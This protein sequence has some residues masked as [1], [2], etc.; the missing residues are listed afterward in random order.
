M[1]LSFIK[2]V[3][4]SEIRLEVPVHD[5]IPYACHYDSN[6]IL[7]KNGELLQTIKL[8]GFSYETIG[9]EKV[10]L[11]DTVRESIL[12]NI[13]NDKLAVW[14][15]TVRTKRSLDPGAGIKYTN[16]FVQET[17][18]AW[19]HKN[20]WDDK[21]VNELYITVIHE[22]HDTKIHNLSDAMLSFSY[23]AQRYIHEEFLSKSH[24]E[25]NQTVNNMLIIL[26]QY[27]AK[28]LEIQEDKEGAYSEL[29]QFFD[30]IIHMKEE[31]I[32]VPLVEL[33]KYLATHKIAFG[34]NSFEVRNG[35]KKYFG[36]I[37]SIKEYSEL[38]ANDIDILLQLPLQLVVTQYMEFGNSKK[39]IKQ[40]DYQRYIVNL[41]NDQ[42]LYK[43][44]GLDAF[45]DSDDKGSSYGYHQL[46]ITIIAEDINSLDQ[47][48]KRAATAL[49]RMG[50]ITVQEDINIEN[51]FWS[52]LPANFSYISRKIPMNL[53]LIG[54]FASLHNFPAGKVSNVW[55]KA[56][57]LFRTALGPPYFFNFHYESS[58]HTFIVGPYSS[59]K[60]TLTNFLITES[61][62]YLPNIFVVDQNYRSK[63]T[64]KAINGIYKEIT[65][66]GPDSEENIC[67]NPLLLPDT[68]DNRSFLCKWFNYIIN[69]ISADRISPQE[70][71]VIE[72][73]VEK[74]YALPV[75]QRKLGYVEQLFPDDTHPDIKEF[76]L[77]NLAKWHG[78]GVYAGLF[79][80]NFSDNLESLLSK[81][82][83]GFDITG[84][85]ASGEELSLP[86]VSYLLYQFKRFLDGRPSI[87]V[88]N[89]A[90]SILNNKI[91]GNELESWLAELTKI[92]AIALIGMEI[93][94]K[95]NENYISNTLIK[96]MDTKIF[97]PDIKVQEYREAFAL[98]DKEFKLVQMMKA[99]NRHF[100]LK[101]G[102]YAIVA[103][104]N[105]TGLDNIIAVLSGNEKMV[106]IADDIIIEQG[107]DVD[108]WLPVFYKQ[109]EELNNEL[110]KVK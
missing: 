68:S 53:E 82:R 11:R 6:T 26:E 62:K 55:G 44:S 101:Q 76:F 69:G 61:C 24:T 22:G 19:S 80:H 58:G 31:R 15:H 49:S 39:I 14:F 70:V 12:K 29:L 83:V 4:N 56:V 102:P 23:S 96:N 72:K 110:L 98:S 50:I 38:S 30:K 109:V 100:L 51:C 78:E 108:K 33:S 48:I 90:W 99:I 5:F 54:G 43:Y 93:S 59:G 3:S 8:V 66:N 95:P 57:T 85:L 71:E 17:H 75:E 106:K 47:S 13:K 84:V 60:T 94:S 45:E 65:L 10:N 77:K 41:T 88:I 103:E 74:L 91:I 63:L 16:K 25:L 73:M 64:I 32:A 87:I 86:I 104:L 40:F 67:I 9:A 36:S 1:V 28:R 105:L 18:N 2:K 97:L 34:N 46:T 52:Q 107:D 7:T 27:G 79:N 89:D 20:Y 37:L 42:E 21:Y 35:S 81:Q 92:N